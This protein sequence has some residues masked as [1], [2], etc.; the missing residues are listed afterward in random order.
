VRLDVHPAAALLPMLSKK[1]LAALAEDIRQHGQRVP[2]LLY[3][4]AILDG[5]NRYA[6]CE[7]LGIVPTFERW[8]PKDGESPWAFVWSLN[9]HRRHLSDDQRVAMRL[10]FEEADETWQEEQAAKR[11]AAEAKRREAIAEAVK[12]QPRGKDGKMGAAPDGGQNVPPSGKKKVHQARVS[13]AAA[14]KVSEGRVKRAKAIKSKDEK[15]FKDVAA[16][17]TSIAKAEKEIKAKERSKATKAAIAEVS[18]EGIEKA[19]RVEACD[20]RD[21]DW[22]E[23]GSVDVIVTDPPYPLE[24][25]SVYSFLSKL[26][27]RVL[28]PGGSMFVMCGQSYL[29]EVMARLAERMEYQWTLAYL[30][31]GGQSVQLWDRKVNTSWSRS[32]GS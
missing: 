29:P 3:D 22:I 15:L 16:G 14:A 8:T 18:A 20:L 28:K 32:S 23:A 1:E 19:A 12:S 4:D 27:A 30:T 24:F 25:I 9:G 7:I 11:E 13:T 31:P 17:T 5:R 10:Q 2:I 26:A 21:T 6:A